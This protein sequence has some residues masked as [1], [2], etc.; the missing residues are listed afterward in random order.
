MDPSID[1]QSLFLQARNPTRNICRFYNIALDRDLFGDWIVT[2][3]YG[4]IGCGGTIRH[5]AYLSYEAA[6]G[7]FKKTLKKRQRARA[8]I[9]CD[10]AILEKE[11]I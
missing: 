2:C 1:A 8:R 4:R 11:A 5:H 6:L 3:C 10:Y 7:F 9:G